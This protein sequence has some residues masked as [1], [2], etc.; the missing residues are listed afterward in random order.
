MTRRTIAFANLLIGLL[1]SLS[2]CWSGAPVP[3]SN[4]EPEPVAQ[5]LAADRA[6]ALM[7]YDADHRHVSEWGFQKVVK[8]YGLKLAEVDLSSTALTDA[9]LRDDAQAYYPTVYIDAKTLETALDQQALALLKTAIRS[10][11]INLFVSALQSGN[12]RALRQL[13][14]GEI[15]GSAQRQDS[16]QDYIISS[17]LPEITR[18]LSGVVIQNDGAQQD[19]GLTLS[20][21]PSHTQVIVAATDD[22]N[23]QYPLYARYQNGVGSVHVVSNLADPVLKHN[24]LEWLYR[25]VRS[26]DTFKQPWFAQ[27]VPMMMFV[28]ATAGDEAWHRN[29]DYVNLT[30]DDPSLRVERFDYQGI[31]KEAILH[32]FHLTI[33]MPPAAYVKSERPVIELF[34]SYPER[35][36]LVQHGNNHDGYEFY[37]YAVDQKDEFPARTFVA[38]EAD[39]VEGR[40]RMEAHKHQTGIPYAPVMIFPYNIGPEQTLALLKRYNF[41]GTIN[42]RD[43][44]IDME[45]NETWDAYMYPAELAYNNLAVIGRTGPQKRAY[46]FNLFIDQPVF[47]YVH[48]DFFSDM[49]AFNTF[50]DTINNAEGAVEWQSIDAIM[51]RLYLEKRNDDGSIDVMFFGNDVVVS[52]N[53]DTSRMYHL[54]R[55]DDG[56]MPIHQVTISGVPSEYALADNQLSVNVMIHAGSA[57][58]LTVR[59]GAADRDFTL[60]AAD[61]SVQRHGTTATIAVRIANVGPTAGPVSAEV[62]DG[63]PYASVS[64]GIG[65]AEQIKPNGS[66]AIRLDTAGPIG[67]QICVALDPYDVILETDENNNIACTH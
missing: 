14:D 9:L 55:A 58:E 53:D 60:A 44:P 7:I 6:D 38:Q 40:T 56:T 23:E 54:R 13:T 10:G 4:A 42:S 2:A 5:A 27:L 24:R 67:G 18:E 65:V 34:R 32:N 47:M 20:A 28:R 39:L 48:K 11:G 8:F 26:G 66:A 16:S 37:Q 30:L 41:Q 52:N 43:Y 19:F 22:Q 31:L 49:Q 62:F 17:A 59:Y 50:A 46:P 61:I 35:L 25:A 45:R 57:R 64:L 29:L 36:S 12:A 21:Q 51:K 63:Q 1:V 15:T 3:P 33:A